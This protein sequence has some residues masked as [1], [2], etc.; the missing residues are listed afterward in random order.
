M[1]AMEWTIFDS[2]W[3]LVLFVVWVLVAYFYSN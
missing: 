1:P 2:A 3:F